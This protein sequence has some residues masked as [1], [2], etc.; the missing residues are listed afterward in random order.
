[1]FWE[2]ALEGVLQDTV[3]LLLCSC[4]SWEASQVCCTVQAEDTCPPRCAD[5]CSLLTS[6]LC[7]AQALP[8]FIPDLGSRKHLRQ[9]YPL[10]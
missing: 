4:R 6:L 7:F 1:M 9:P 10:S 5:T 8:C 3:K 2:L